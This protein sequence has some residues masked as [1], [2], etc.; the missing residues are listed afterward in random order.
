MNTLRVWGGGIYEQ[1]EF[2]R[3]CDELG[4]MVGSR[5]H[6]TDMLLYPHFELL[7][8]ESVLWLVPSFLRARTDVPFFAK[9]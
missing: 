4:I 7:C 2:Y 1:E 5:Q 6:F 9:E 3:L 8:S